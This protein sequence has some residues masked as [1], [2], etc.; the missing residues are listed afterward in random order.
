MSE[1]D[2]RNKKTLKEGLSQEQRDELA[3]AKDKGL[4]GED[5]EKTERA[6]FDKEVLRVDVPP[7]PLSIPPAPF[8]ERDAAMLADKHQDRRDS[9]RVKSTPRGKE[10]I[11]HDAKPVPQ[12]DS[13]DE[14]PI[15]TYKKIDP[16][17]R[18]S[19]AHRG[20][21]RKH[22][23]ARARA[24]QPK[25]RPALLLAEYRSAGDCL[26]AAEKLRDAGYTKFDTH[27][28]FPVHGMDRAMGL[29]DSKLGW[30]VLVCGL[31]GTT[32]A[33]A[34]M[35][36]MNDIDYPL[37]IGG[38]PPTVGSLPSMIPIMFE[39]T[40]L[41]AAFG[42]VF[43]MFH[44]NRLPR[45]H[46]PVFESERFRA[47]SDDKFFVSVEVEDPKFKLDRTRELLDKTRPSHVEL[48]EEEV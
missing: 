14:D 4:E 9:V 21:G 7:A 27:T 25:M 37:V 26:H 45:H 6:S 31:T 5:D 24:L 19:G 32:A 38:K 3:R 48:V 12:A 11:A 28:P 15:G 13:D 42:A 29:P 23:S 43:G 41:L 40:V 35:H 2:L 39:L 17:D 20:P 16:H 46:H 8:S 47:F 18:E 10:D 36:W 34:M 33:F 22:D 1:D 30:I 44:L